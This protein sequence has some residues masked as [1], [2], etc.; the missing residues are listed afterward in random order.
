MAKIAKGGFSRAAIEE[1]QHLIKK[2]HAEV[3]EVMKWRVEFPGDGK[4]KAAIE[5]HPAMVYEIKLTAAFLA[6]MALQRF[7]GHAGGAKAQVHLLKS[8]ANS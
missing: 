5:R 8:D 3:R 6:K 1:T 7:H 4:V 2:P